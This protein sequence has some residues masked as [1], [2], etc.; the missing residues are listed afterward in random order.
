MASSILSTILLLTSF[1]T[2]PV[3]DHGSLQSALTFHAGFDGTFD[4]GFSKGDKKLYTSSSMKRT[5]SKSGNGRDD[6]TFIAKGK[7]GKAIRFGDKAKNVVFY[8]VKD[9]FE[10]REEN[11]SGTVSFWLRL[12]TQKDLKPGYA[13][14]IQ[15][16]QKAWNDSSFFIDFTKDDNPRHVRLGTFSDLKF[17]NPDKIKW[18]K[19]PVEKRPLVTVKKPPFS[20]SEW[21]HLAFTFTD[22]NTEGKTG[23]ASF[24]LNG[25]LAGTTIQPQQFKWNIDKAA[26]MLGLSYIGDFDDLAIFNRALS[27]EE[28]QKLFR[29]PSGVGTI[30]ST[31]SSE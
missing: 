14:P 24:Y 9:N 15:I 22:F 11:W 6:L 29:L 13:D 8:K 23:K 16:T 19:I 31:R 4:A 28:I 25:K 3:S 18:D 1:G 30:Y 2:D 20:R 7:Y 12:D 21:T 17:W 5:D 10:F 27:A 26:I